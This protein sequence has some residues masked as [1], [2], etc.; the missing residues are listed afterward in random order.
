MA[1]LP[2]GSI[3]QRGDRLALRMPGTRAR[4]W[5]DKGTTRDEAQA[6][7]ANVVAHL[8][9]GGTTPKIV[10]KLGRGES[11]AKYA[12]RWIADRVTRKMNSAPDDLSRLK[13]HVLPHLKGK[14]MLDVTRDD[15]EVVVQALDAKILAGTMS[16]KTAMNV[17]SCVTSMFS[18]ATKTKRTGLRVLAT[19]PARDVEGPD[20]GAQKEGPFLYPG[21]AD[22]LLSSEHV[23]VAW[24]RRYALAIYLGLRIGELAELRARDVDLAAGVVRIERAL[25]RSG[26]IEGTKGK[27]RRAVPI[28]PTLR[29]WLAALVEAAKGE[30]DRLLCPITITKGA[31]RLKLDIKAAGLTR[32]QLFTDDAHRRSLAFHDLRHT[33]ATWCAIRGDAPLSI[34]DRHGHKHFSTTEKYVNEVAPLDRNSLGVPFGPLPD[35][36]TFVQSS[37]QSS[38]VDVSDP[39]NQANLA[40]ESGGAGNRTLV[41]EKNEAAS[42]QSKWTFDKNAPIADNE[43]RDAVESALADALAAA[44]AAGRFDVV[45][46]LA[47]ELEARRLA[48]ANV[49]DLSAVRRERGSR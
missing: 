15:L 13:N 40:A 45:A 14:A 48:R 37:T 16:P 33:S 6:I 39:A 4:I 17:W 21:E 42:S 9:R 49:V 38:T 20:K 10:G 31:R 29:P 5:L 12:E 3:E 44:V 28:E 36:V 47:N 26:E 18:D 11:V 7:L 46:K 30:P 19:N 34:R 27:D 23:P 2:T 24:R 8:S 35:D 41:G 43:S 25:K 1:R 32:S 22:A